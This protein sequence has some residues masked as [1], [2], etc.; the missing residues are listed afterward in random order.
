[1]KEKLNKRLGK[2]EVKLSRLKSKVEYLDHS[3][4]GNVKPS[5]KILKSANHMEILEYYCCALFLSPKRPPVS[6]SD[7]TTLESLY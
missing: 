6:N 1:L 5:S 2:Q 4:T 7:A 3:F